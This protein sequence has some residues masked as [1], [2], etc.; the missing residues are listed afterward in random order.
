[1]RSFVVSSSA[2]AELLAG[3]CRDGRPPGSG[4][5]APV[6][7]RFG[8]RVVLRDYQMRREA[9]ST[10]YRENRAGDVVP[11]GPGQLRA[12]CTTFGGAAVTIGERAKQDGDPGRTSAESRYASTRP[13]V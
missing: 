2:A 10:R 9:S 1:M 3:S 8:H 6:D 5:A 4:S 7:R 13:E 11:T 12:R